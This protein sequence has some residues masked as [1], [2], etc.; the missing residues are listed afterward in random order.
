MPLLIALALI[1]AV[2]WYAYSVLKKEL[3][4]LAEQDRKEAQKRPGTT[5]GK[6]IDELE[7][8]P[9]TGVYRPKKMD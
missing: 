2:G 1:G 8:D 7:Q 9:E 5:G 3:A 4:K 6:V